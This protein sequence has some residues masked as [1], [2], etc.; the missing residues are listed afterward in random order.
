MTRNIL[1]LLIVGVLGSAVLAGCKDKFIRQRYETIHVG[2]SERQVR[3]TLGKWT[4]KSGNEWHYIRSDPVYQKAVIRFE[5]GHVV[6]TKWWDEPETGT[7]ATQEAP[8][9]R[10]ALENVAPK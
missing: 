5:D 3:K 2:F 6:S 9:E 8:D 10:D 7:A 1:L 4:Y